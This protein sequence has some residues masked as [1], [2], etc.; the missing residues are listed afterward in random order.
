MSQK[1]HVLDFLGACGMDTDK[2]FFKA[3]ANMYIPNNANL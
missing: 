3:S 1:K 2:V